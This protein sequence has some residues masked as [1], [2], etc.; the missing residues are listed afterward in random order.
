MMVGYCPFVS[1]VGCLGSFVV[2]ETVDFVSYCDCNFVY[3]D[4]L[5]AV[6]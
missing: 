4:L 1:F 3:S 5:V 2:V 6:S